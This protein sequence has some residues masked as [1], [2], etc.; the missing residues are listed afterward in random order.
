MEAELWVPPFPIAAAHV[1]TSW[2]RIRRRKAAG[3]HGL[4]PIEWPDVD[5]FARYTGARLDTHDIEMLEALDD[6][7]IS[8]MSERATPSDKQ[9]ALKDGLKA[10]GRNPRK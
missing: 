10:A 5:A 8:K 9:Q 3:Q 6:L 2:Q 4:D 1:W 7:F